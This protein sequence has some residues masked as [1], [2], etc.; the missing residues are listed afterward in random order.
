MTSAAGRW[1]RTNVRTAVWEILTLVSW[2]VLYLVALLGAMAAVIAIAG[3]WD[4]V[5]VTSG[6]MS[7]TLRAG[8]VIFIEERPDE[9]LGQRSVITFER[10]G[11][12]GD[13]VTHRIFEVLS[14]HQSYVTK[15]DANPTV[16]SDPVRH[17]DVVG[18]GRMVVPFLGLPVVWSAQGNIGAL[19]ALAVLLFAALATS[20]ASV[21]R[22]R[23]DHSA[24]D[25]RFSS[26]D[27]RG[28]SR[29]RLVVALMIGMQFFVQDS[30]FDLDIIGIT[31]VHALVGSL[32]F[33]GAISLLAN[34]RS[35]TAVGA[36]ARRLATAELAGDTLVVVFFVAATGISGIGWVLMALPIIE[37]AIHFRLTGAFV[38]WMLMCGLTIGVFFWI[39]SSLGT[40]SSVVIEE[41]GQLTDQLGVLLMVVIPGSY[42]AEQLLGDVLTQRRE[43]EKAKARSRIMEQVTEAGHGVTRLGG[44]LFDALA[45]SSLDLGFDVADAWIR[46]TA[47]HWQLLASAGPA[48]L[49]PPPPD[50]PGS[51]L[52][53]ADLE[54]AEVFIDGDDPDP[55]Q[56]GALADSGTQTLV[57]ITL[58]SVED[59]Y[60]VLRVATQRLSDDAASQIMAL[61]M[62]CG[63]AAVALQNEQLLAELRETHAELQHQAMRDALTGLANRAQFVEWLGTSLAGESAGHRAHTVMFLDLNGFKAVNDRLGHLAGDD[64]LREVGGRLVAAVGNR[65]RVAR[66]GGDEFT[67]LVDDSTG[68]HAAAEIADAIHL[69][70]AAPFD[71]N[72]DQAAVGAAIGIAFIEPGLGASEILRRADTA[73]YSAKQSPGTWR[74]A[75]YSAGLDV[76]ARR[77]EQLAVDFRT[78]LAQDQLTLAY[79]PILETATGRVA[80]AEALLRWSH[81]ELGPVAAPL[82]V[83]LAEMTGSVD[84]LNAWVFATALSD[85]AACQLPTDS[86]FFVA[87]NVSPRELELP[88]LVA[89]MRTAIER[90]GM[91]P[92]NVVVELSERIVAL[93]HGESA[94][95]TGLTDLGLSLALD[96]FGEGQTSLGHLRTLPIRFLKLDRLFVEQADQSPADRT[97]LDSVVN[98]AHDLGFAVIAE[99]IETASQHEIVAGAGADLL[100][101]YGL[102]RPMTIW[103][104]SRLLTGPVPPAALLARTTQSVEGVG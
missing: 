44:Q 97:V 54:L 31:R 37:A 3:N 51:A 42:L 4:P 45:D 90:S 69:A 91:P 102:H 35:R 38:H 40:P 103:D 71:I 56:S 70:L 26:G 94:N 61:R 17:D 16:D 93:G 2:A 59:A 21:I 29:V 1:L 83:E 64:L 5:V 67:V 80:G 74:T 63:Q 86:D 9:L 34:Y 66:L 30:D 18:V 32:V 24:D 22:T 25:S 43:T 76:N 104:L 87:V 50:A 89:N 95:V 68:R 47:D 92:S 99:G 58:S 75:T 72:G 100:Q 88:S 84:E 36:V 85:V 65:G 52:Q 27:Q 11:A 28:I 78:S 62:L 10:D 49:Q 46:T 98:L 101:G 7:P 55:E 41:L 73:M 82:I 60:I 13:L 96:D 19:V 20:V 53:P 15:G 81:W 23:T 48:N 79:Q 8:D 12:D 33:L 39:Q 14:D 77:R 6:S 57:R